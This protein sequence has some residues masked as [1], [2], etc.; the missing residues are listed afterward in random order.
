MTPEEI[1][2]HAIKF[3]TWVNDNGWI[4]DPFPLKEY[5][6]DKMR[7]SNIIAVIDSGAEELKAFTI[8]E[9][10]DQFI[11]QQPPSAE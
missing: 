3:I 2:Q 9:L 11:N 4:R 6:D 7:Y 10:Y 5:N 1:K 8:E